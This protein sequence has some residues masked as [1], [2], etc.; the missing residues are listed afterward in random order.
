[1]R[2]GTSMSSTAG[3]SR[4][5]RDAARRAAR[6]GQDAAVVVDLQRADAGREVDDAGQ[7]ARR[8]SQRHQRVH[9][10]AQAQVEHQRA[11]FDQQVRVAGAAIRRPRR[12]S[13]GRCEAAQHRPCVGAATR[14][15]TSP[16]LGTASARSAPARPSVSISTL[17]A[18]LQRGRL[19]R[20][21]R[22]EADACRPGCS[23]PIFHSSA[24]DDRRR[25]DEAAEA[26][27]VGAEDDRH[28]AGEVDGADGV[29]VVVDV[30][31]VQAGL[32]AVGARPLGLGADQA[33][34]GAAGV[35]VHLPVGGEERRDVVV[36]EE[37]GRAVRAVEHADLASCGRARGW[38]A[39]QRAAAVARRGL[40]ATDAQH[41]AA[42]SARPPWP[43][44]CPSVKVARLPR[45]DRHVEAAADREVG[46]AAGPVDGAERE[47][48]ARRARRPAR[49]LGTADAVERGAHARAG[50]RDHA[51]RG[52][53]SV[54]PVTVI[55]SPARSPGCRRA[56]GEAEATAR[57]SAPTA[58][59]RRPSSRGGPDS[60]ARAEGAGARAPRW[61]ACAKR[62]AARMRGRDL[63]RDEQR[64]VRRAARR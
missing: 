26:R 51:P 27:A 47:R 44:N 57:P 13:P 59:R 10:E 4:S 6:L 30:G 16:A 7:R 14:A 55:S 53:R 36:G 50:Q 8:S 31:R 9:A 28:V 54:G 46:A 18:R 33:D 32:A 52:K 61:T 21:E 60:P 45:Y 5:A 24:C 15:A 64:L 20:G 43:P 63:P 3:S 37:V 58:A 17:P 2:V 42:R 25:A 1:M 23:W 40:V 11:V 38:S 48:L 12:R 19:R 41:V 34:A 49:Q 35:V 56:V 29:G 22:D 39:G 62:D